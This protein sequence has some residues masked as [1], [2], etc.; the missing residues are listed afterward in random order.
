M[1]QGFK[2]R[3]EN[4]SDPVIPLDRDESLV[5]RNKIKVSPLIL[6]DKAPLFLVT[7]RYATASLYTL[8]ITL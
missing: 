3:I 4:F 2:R 8:T 5:I 7:N 6:D 1:I